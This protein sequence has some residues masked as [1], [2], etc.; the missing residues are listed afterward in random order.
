MVDLPFLRAA[1]AQ[2][3]HGNDTFIQD[4]LALQLR[5]LS[6]QR[7]IEGEIRA[8]K[9]NWEPKDPGSYGKVTEDSL[10]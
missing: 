8:R 3:S 5:I 6:F 2:I 7:M 1:C 4:W 10:L 9:P